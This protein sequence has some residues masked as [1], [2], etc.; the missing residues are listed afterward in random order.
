MVTENITMSNGGIELRS[1]VKFCVALNKSPTKLLRMIKSTRKYDKCRPGFVYKCHSHFRSGREST[2]D[3]F[4]SGQPAVVTCFIK[5]LVKDMVNMDRRTTVR[6]IA[7]EL[8]VSC[9]TVHG[10]LT[11]ELKMCRY[12][13]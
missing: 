1:V 12:C 2:E 10:I 7:D 4:R 13:R 3:D 11:E 5:N 9:S 6:V 8:G